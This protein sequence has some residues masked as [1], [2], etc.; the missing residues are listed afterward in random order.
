MRINDTLK[1]D[2]A[3]LCTR[4]GDSWRLEGTAFFVGTDAEFTILPENVH[5]H[6]VTAKHVIEHAKA[7]GPLFLRVNLLAGG[8][9]NLPLPDKWEYSD[10]NGEEIE[11]PGAG[12][13]KF[14]KDID[15]AVMLIDLQESRH[16]F[17]AMRFKGRVQDETD[18]I[19]RFGIGI[20]DELI[21]AGLF[22][23]RGG[24]HRN[25]P[26]IRSGIIS[27]MPDEPIVD[28]DSREAYSVYLAEMRS[29]GGLSGSPV[30][31]MLDHGADPSRITTRITSKLLGLIRGH[32]DYKF[33]LESIADASGLDMERVN[34][35]IAMI[36]PIQEVAKIMDKKSLTDERRRREQEALK[37]STHK[38][39]LD[40]AQAALP[41]QKTHAGV[42]IPIPA[43]SQFTRD[44]LKAIRKRKS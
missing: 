36:T 34:T 31:T 3:F 40:S 30:L 24:L 19:K 39:T 32:W 33:V 27:A 37:K 23:E 43:R 9:E 6:L 20:G 28:F 38:P 41:T 26:V 8:V 29:L 16:R 13:G 22:T 15:A 10:E 11:V 42:D 5:V 17:R 18:D 35:G 7:R 4:D 14:R 12:A 1:D 44:L 25:I 2:V 21:V